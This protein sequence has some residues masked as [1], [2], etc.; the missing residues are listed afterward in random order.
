M[1]KKKVMLQNIIKYV[2]QNTDKLSVLQNI[3]N[4]LKNIKDELKIIKNT[5]M[6]T[7]NITNNLTILTYM[8]KSKVKEIF[9]NHYTLDTFLGNEKIKFKFLK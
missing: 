7:N 6:L 8:T 9:D 1:L 5:P 4:E 2:N 3:T